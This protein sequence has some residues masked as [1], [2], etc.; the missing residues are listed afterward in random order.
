MEV[1]ILKKNMFITGRIMPESF[2]SIRTC[3]IR[4]I[5]L[6][7]KI[8]SSVVDMYYSALPL[9]FGLISHQ[10]KSKWYFSNKNDR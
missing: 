5:V 10:I 1:D 4:L 8:Q 2:E 3:H 9:I 6:K 7:R